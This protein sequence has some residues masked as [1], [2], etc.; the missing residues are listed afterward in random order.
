MN[1]E[2]LIKYYNKFNENKRLDHRHGIVEFNTTINYILKYLKKDNNILDVGAG[3]GKYSIYLDNLGYDVTAVELVKHNLAQIPK[4]IKS[5]QGNALDL[6][7]FN[8]ESFDIVLLFGPLYHLISL[9]EKIKAIN[10]AK[11]VLK[12]DG[13]IFIQYY[14]RDY[15]II[16]HGF[17]NQNILSSLNNMDSNFNIISDNKDLYSYST[18]KDI[19]LLNEKCNLKR[20]KILTPDGLTDILRK[21]I[22]KLTDEEFDLYLKYHLSVCEIGRAHV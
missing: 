14:M 17:I 20:V 4:N 19:N 3:T 11:R 22:N 7:K 5:Y 2:N 8:D 18:L 9:E 12:K 1:E 21:D 16:K 6:S 10:E 13:L 15:A